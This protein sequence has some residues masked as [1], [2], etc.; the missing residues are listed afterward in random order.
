MKNAIDQTAKSEQE[1]VND[2]LS[3]G[4]NSQ[5]DSKSLVTDITT[6][7]ETNIKNENLTSC[8]AVID[9]INDGKLKITGNLDCPTGLNIAQQ[10]ASDQLAECISE[11]LIDVL[12]ANETI[13]E[14]VQNMNSK[15][16]AENKG[17]TDFLKN[18]IGPLII[19]AIIIVLVLIAKSVFTRNPQPYMGGYGG[20]GGPGVSV[21]AS[22]NART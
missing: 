8:N 6:I 9:N 20:Y 18:L 11:T 12:L 21:G 1:A 10:I 4:L 22:I 3:L 7:I 19:I 14:A 2:F 16:K 13:N 15:Q 5:G 17:I